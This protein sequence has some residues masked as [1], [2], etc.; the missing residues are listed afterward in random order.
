MNA[1]AFVDSNIVLYMMSQ[2]VR[3]AQA[4]RDLMATCPRLS[5]QVLNEVVNV[6]R[7]KLAMPWREIDQFLQLVRGLCPIE[8]LTVETHDLGRMIGERHKLSVYDAMI[9]SSAL[10]SGC[11]TLYSEDMQ[12][13]LR[14]ENTL[15]IVNPFAG[16]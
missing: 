1:R 7:R 6:T 8:P 10:L 3:K 11:E 5:V 15:T 13:G 4:A 2:D 16:L 14:I 9:V 12:S